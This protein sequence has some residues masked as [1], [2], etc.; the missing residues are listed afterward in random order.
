[1]NTETMTLIKL[2]IKNAFRSYKYSDEERKVF[3][4]FTIQIGHKYF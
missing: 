3:D 4:T 2:D 1:M